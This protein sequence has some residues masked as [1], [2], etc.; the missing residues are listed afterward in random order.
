MTSGNRGR[1]PWVA[2]LLFIAL[3]ALRVEADAPGPSEA[4]GPMA[5]SRSAW[6]GKGSD[7]EKDPWSEPSERINRLR[8]KGEGRWREMESDDRSGL[9]TE[10]EIPPSIQRLRQEGEKRQREARLAWESRAQEIYKMWGNV[11][12]PG[13][14]V[15]VAYTKNNRAFGKVD[16]EKGSLEVGAIA[17]VFFQDAAL[18]IERLLAE[19]LTFL[20]RGQSMPGVWDLEDQ[21]RM[22]GTGR[23]ITQAEV[24]RFSRDVAGSGEPPQSY[25]APDGVRRL[26]KQIKIDLVPDH[27]Q[28]RV[29]QYI[30][31]VEKAAR[32][33][34]VEPELILAVIE[35]ESV[36]N[37]HAISHAGAVGLMQ[38][39]PS[40]G[41]LEASK[42][43]Y[44]EPRL[45]TREEL[46]QADKNIELG[47]AYLRI[48]LKRHFSEYQVEPRKR[49]FLVIASYNCGPRRVKNALGN[50][51][52]RGLSSAE[53]YDLLLRVVPGETQV[54]LKRVV[55]NMKQ[56]ESIMGRAPR[57]RFG[58]ACLPVHR[59]NPPPANARASLRR[60]I[61]LRDGSSLFRWGG[62]ALRS[63]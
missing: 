52:T 7:L 49:L 5:Q 17:P 21:I 18:R 47:A 56:Y 19:R 42:L 29:R 30:P 60:L 39:V 20:L 10:E 62:T 8:F 38:L 37:P 58:F 48:L 15:H 16:Y 26:R 1:S 25:T 28:A 40:S 14:T 45:L 9:G 33:Y 51:D 50:R 35:T 12:E 46:I 23:L 24:Q 41:A 54:Y 22:P 13:P 4:F 59:S 31:H 2:L 44:G 32:I 27:L 3:P 34:E 36:F 6:S 63:S 53:F 43:V 55:R 11:R 57:F 61:F